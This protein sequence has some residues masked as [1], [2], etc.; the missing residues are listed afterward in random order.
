MK[1]DKETYK[2]AK[3]ASDGFE[4]GFLNFVEINTLAKG[5]RV[6]MANYVREEIFGQMALGD[7]THSLLTKEPFHTPLG[8]WPLVKYIRG[9]LIGESSQLAANGSTYPFMKW[10][11]TVKKCKEGKDGKLDVEISESYTAELSDEI[12]FQPS[13]VEMWKPE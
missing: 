10:K 8:Y 2:S 3:I 6:Q 11:T 4:H 7:S 5:C 12:T 13:S 1:G 9:K